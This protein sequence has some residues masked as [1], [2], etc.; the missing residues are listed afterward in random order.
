MTHAAGVA[1][2]L[3]SNDV[4]VDAMATVEVGLWRAVEAVRGTAQADIDAGSAT[5]GWQGRGVLVDASLS[6][7]APHISLVSGG[8]FTVTRASD[9]AQSSAVV[10]QDVLDSATM[11]VSAC[12]L[13]ALGIAMAGLE[14]RLTALAERQKYAPLQE[15]SSTSSSAS[16]LQVVTWLRGVSRAKKRLRALDLPV[17][18]GGT[19]QALRALA[20]QLDAD[21]AAQLPDALAREL[22]LSVPDA[23][24]RDTRWPLKEWADTLTQVVGNLA[25]IVSEMA[26]HEAPT[27]ATEEDVVCIADSSREAAQRATELN[28]VIQMT[29]FGGVRAGSG[30]SPEWPTLQQLHVLALTTV[31]RA[32]EQ[33]TVLVAHPDI[34]AKGTG[35]EIAAGWVDRVIG[36]DSD[37]TRAWPLQL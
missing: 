20:E 4:L 5:L 22:R 16:G 17:Q 33:L 3:T 7:A 37:A 13:D 26:D 12:V 25:L 14:H 34:I 27:E 30:S 23:P 35:S 32:S 19:E 36:L 10:D 18:V 31:A 2:Q 29:S 21:A 9:F 1:E 15:G 8:T 28:A 24:W 11:L 6:T